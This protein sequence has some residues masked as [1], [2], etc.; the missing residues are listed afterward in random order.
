MAIARG[1]L[2]EGEVATDDV[3]PRGD[4]LEILCRRLDVS[5]GAGVRARA[6]GDAMDVLERLHQVEG[7]IVRVQILR[8]G[9][10]VASL[11]R[12]AARAHRGRRWG[13]RYP[14]GTHKARHARR[15]TASA[16]RIVVAESVLKGGHPRRARTRATSASA[17][18]VKMRGVVVLLSALLALALPPAGCARM[19]LQAPDDNLPT[20]IVMWH[21]SASR[22]AARSPSSRAVPNLVPFPRR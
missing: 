4:R 15:S 6:G 8:G 22:C 3:A 14:R 19:L 20:P 9:H 21:G 5:V 18:L 12:G 2:D 1:G 7:K 16:R 10:R 11:V 13:R 17:D